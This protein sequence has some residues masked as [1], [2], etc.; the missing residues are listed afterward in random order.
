MEELQV[1]QSPNVHQQGNGQRAVH[2]YSRI[3]LSNQKEQTTDAHD[4][5]ESDNHCGE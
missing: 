2:P 3:L 4:R 5:H 1:G